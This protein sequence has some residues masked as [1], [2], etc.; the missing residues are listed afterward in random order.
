MSYYNYSRRCRAAL[1]PFTRPPSARPGQP[2]N[3]SARKAPPGKADDGG[4]VLE[5]RGGDFNCAPQELN[6]LVLELCEELRALQSR[7]ASCAR[8]SYN[9]TKL[10][11]DAANGKQGTSPA[12]LHAETSG[13]HPHTSFSRQA[14]KRN[15]YHFSYPLSCCPSCSTCCRKLHGCVSVAVFKINIY[16]MCHMCISI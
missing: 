6:K 5:S 12:Q 11:L 4:I 13:R 14:P 2:L 10:H 1:G 3:H 15:R 7:L 16:I 9:T 8:R